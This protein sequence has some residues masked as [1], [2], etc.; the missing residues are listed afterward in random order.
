VGTKLGK[1]FG[2]AIAVAVCAVS[3]YLWI[4]T[5]GGFSFRRG[6]I[7]LGTIFTLVIVA[8]LPRRPAWSKG[9]KIAVL[10]GG[11][12]WIISDML[13]I[14]TVWGWLLSILLAA[15]CCILGYLILFED[16]F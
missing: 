7:A 8:M 5:L 12:C 15:V 9:I 16:F 1:L 10:T 2:S 4:E 6:L 11:V 3:I 14:E 13:P